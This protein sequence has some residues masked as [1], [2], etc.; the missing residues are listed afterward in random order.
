MRNADTNTLAD[1]SISKPKKPS[2]PSF[3]ADGFLC[4]AP[5]LEDDKMNFRFG[6]GILGKK[7]F[8]I[9]CNK[10][11]SRRERRTIIPRA[12]TKKT[13]TNNS[14]SQP[15]NNDDDQ[16]ISI[17]VSNFSLLERNIFVPNFYS[18]LPNSCLKHFWGR[19]VPMKKVSL[20]GPKKKS[21]KKSGVSNQT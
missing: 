18:D 3:S 12:L 1:F 4:L 13:T 5:P 20:I 8:I 9:S 7:H 2:L 6:F 15:C 10:Y 16:G 19:H 21:D 14:S 11:G 17:I